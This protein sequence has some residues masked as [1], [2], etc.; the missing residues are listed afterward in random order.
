MEIKYVTTADYNK[1][2]S[3]TLD[4]KITLENLVNEYDLNEMIKTLATNEEIKTSA[5]KAESKA[6]QD[7]IAKLQIFDSSLFI[8]Q[9][10]FDKDGIQ[11]YLVFQPIYK[12]ITAFSGLTSTTLEWE[13]K[14]LSNE[15]FTPP[16]KA[17]KSLSPKLIW[18]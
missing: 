12:T 8:G 16:Y 3:N 4:S 6:E 1:F 5:T 14:G 2:T 10:Y 13:S 18:N 11:L 9:S 7:E 15:K 17:N